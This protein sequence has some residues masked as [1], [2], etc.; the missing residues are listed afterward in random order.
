MLENL[1]SLRHLKDIAEKV[2]KGNAAL[3]VV[4]GHTFYCVLLTFRGCSV[5]GE[6]SYYSLTLMQPPN[7]VI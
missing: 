3:L 5:P 7:L 6:N 2:T 4:L 1:H